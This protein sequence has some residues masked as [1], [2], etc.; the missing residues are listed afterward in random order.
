[1]L[2]LVVVLV[3]SASSSSLLLPV[4]KRALFSMY[5]K[6]RLRS[7]RSCRQ[8]PPRPRPL[9]PL[10]FTSL[11]HPRPC[12]RGTP[13]LFF[14]LP[15]GE[16]GNGTQR[17]TKLGLLA[18]WAPR[19]GALAFLSPSPFALQT[20]KQTHKKRHDRSPLLYL[21]YGTYSLLLF[22]AAALRLPPDW[23]SFWWIDHTK[24]R[25]ALAR[26]RPAPSL[27]ALLLRAWL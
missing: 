13:C 22:A 26:P 8:A 5:N 11:R 4:A 12:L 20:Q 6:S 9:A 21:L 15:G 2:L 16:G 3:V 27:S 10:P 19:G 23:P 25:G 17:N 14:P 24:C 1:M 7:P 18:V